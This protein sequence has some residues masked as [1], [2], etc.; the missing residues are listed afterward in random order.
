MVN[1]DPVFTYG[2]PVVTYSQR[3]NQF[4]ISATEA[5]LGEYSFTGHIQD[6]EGYFS[7]WSFKVTVISLATA[8]D[9]G[10]EI[11]SPD[12]PGPG[13]REGDENEEEN[14]R[15]EGDREN[16]GD[17]EEG[18][19][20]ENNEGEEGEEENDENEREGENT[21][22]EEDLAPILSTS[23]QS[24]RKGSRLNYQPHITNLDPGEGF[25]VTVSTSAKATAPALSWDSTNN[26]FL[27]DASSS[28]V[29]IKDHSFI[30][31]IQDEN[32][33]ANS[34]SLIVSVTQA[35]IVIPPPPP[36]SEI[37]VLNREM[38]APDGEPPQS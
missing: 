33:N 10:I 11:P 34:W 29:L 35:P 12:R 15:D 22:S 9:L 16:E 3:N 5:E 1:V 8:E 24:V 27:I 30:G 6:E 19:N 2:S 38:P 36:A 4:N 13:V 7:Y 21:G 31:T 37:R 17:E 26:S 28:S 23:K 14:E 32:G 18:E 25:T 20:G